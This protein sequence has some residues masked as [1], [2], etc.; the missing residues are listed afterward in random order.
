MVFQL[1]E[2]LDGDLLAHSL[3]DLV[4]DPAHLVLQ[5]LP[6]EL[7]ELL[8]RVFQR[9]DELVRQ[10]AQNTRLLVHLAELCVRVVAELDE[11]EL[12]EDVL[13]ELVFG[14]IFLLLRLH[15][16][17]RGLLNQI[18]PH[19]LLNQ[20]RLVVR[21]LLAPPVSDLPLHAELHGLVFQVDVVEAG[22]IH[23]R[24]LRLERLLLQLALNLVHDEA[25]G[26]QLEAVL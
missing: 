23:G 7:P 6:G 16:G 2:A 26:V 21:A 4:H 22:E 15:Q 9:H 13:E 14:R 5:R 3:F 24:V 11:A 8:R 18:E 20:R 19:N 10:L 25:L 12:V 17:L 1:L